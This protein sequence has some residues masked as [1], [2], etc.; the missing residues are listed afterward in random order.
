MI[1]HSYQ[2]GA[3]PQTIMLLDGTELHRCPVPAPLYLSRDG[4]VFY[5]Y[6]IRLC[7]RKIQTNKKRNYCKRCPSGSTQGQR[8]P[9]IRAC[10]KVY[11]I[12]VLMASTFHGPRPTDEQGKPFE[13]HHLNGIYTDNRAD[14]LIWLSHEEHKIYD[15]QLKK[16]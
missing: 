3:T 16:H 12:H 4:R 5:L 2:R 14:N 1:I 9:F 7:E 6:R 13:C 15:K 8:Y 10:H 11:Y